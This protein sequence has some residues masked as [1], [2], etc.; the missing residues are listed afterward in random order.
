MYITCTHKLMKLHLPIFFFS[1]SFFKKCTF[2]YLS[3]K[4]SQV[5]HD[6][7]RCSTFVVVTMRYTSNS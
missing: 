4:N 3:V 1:F 7:V 5:L 6:I 2:Y